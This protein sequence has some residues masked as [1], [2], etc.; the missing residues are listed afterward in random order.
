[1]TMVIDKQVRRDRRRAQAEGVKALEASGVLDDL[2]ARIDAGEVE[3]KDGLIQQLIKAG[4]ERSLQSPCH[5]GPRPPR[6]VQDRKWKP[7]A[8][9][10]TDRVQ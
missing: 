10:P 1:M 9:D 3:G 8:T 6:Y 5:E 4:L 2:Y 7:T